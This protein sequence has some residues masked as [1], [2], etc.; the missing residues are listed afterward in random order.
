MAIGANCTVRGFGLCGEPEA[1]PAAHPEL[2]EYL[3][4]GCGVCLSRDQRC[5]LA[6]SQAR[7]LRVAENLTRR[8]KLR[9]GYLSWFSRMDNR[10]FLRLTF[11]RGITPV[12][13]ALSR[14][15]ATSRKAVVASCRSPFS[16]A[17]R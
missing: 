6:C 2:K 12:L 17:A 15:E 16:T 14:A 9:R 3:D 1:A 5:T 10:D 7:K 11:A 13:T 4:R 8:E